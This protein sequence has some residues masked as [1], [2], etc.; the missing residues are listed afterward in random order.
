MNLKKLILYLALSL[1]LYACADYQKAKTIIDKEKLYFS[2]T[3]FALVYE[4]NLYAQKLVTRK[5]NND[6]IAVMHSILKRGTPV[7]IINPENSKVVETKID[8]KAKYPKIFNVVISKKVASILELNIDNPYVEIIEV[9]KNRTFVAK[10]SNTFEE[11]KKVADKAPVEK[12]K[13]NIL[14]KGETENKEKLIK[15]YS[16]LL[17][18]NDFYYLDSASNLKKEL[19]KKIKSNN[20]KVKKI[21]NTKYRLYAGPFKNFNALKTTYISLNDLGFENLNIYKE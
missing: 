3:G 5:L 7:K 15:E 1:Q 14:T 19:S 6:S 18:V 21:N 10:E 13:M 20:F 12:I 17:I 9:K 2:S 16:F 4:N 11:E 8:K